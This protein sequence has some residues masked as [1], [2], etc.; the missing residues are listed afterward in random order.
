MA[1]RPALIELV[2]EPPLAWIV[3][4]HP[5][6]LNAWSWESARQITAH[7]ERL[8]FDDEIRAVIVRAEGRAFC[9]GVDLGMPEDRITGRSPAEKTRNYF[10]RFRWVH[11]RFDLLVELPQP[12]VMAIHGYCLGA[13]L[14]VAM[15][16]DIRIAADDARFALPE[17]KVGVSIDAGGDLRLITEIGAG[18]T[19][20]LAFTGRRI[21]A[22]TALRLGIVQEVVPRDALRD[23]ARALGLEIAANAPLAVQAIKRTINFW[24]ERGL[25]EAMRFVA[26][27]SAPNFVSDDMA[28]GYRAGAERRPPSFEGK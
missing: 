26:A 23:H 7:A 4:N 1:D 27:S 20:L 28:E 25:A 18:A 14:E 24:A 15:M 16:G 9:A 5:E 2:R 13:G 11:E 22:E 12:V 21:D 3:L 17:P 10:E 8:R 19:R 6:K